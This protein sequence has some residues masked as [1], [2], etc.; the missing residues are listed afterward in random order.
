MRLS[1][2][3]CPLSGSW[4]SPGSRTELCTCSG[5]ELILCDV[6]TRPGP[7]GIATFRWPE[8]LFE[9]W[10][11]GP[12]ESEPGTSTSPHGSFV[13]FAVGA[14][15]LRAWDIADPKTSVGRDVALFREL[16]VTNGAETVEL[17]EMRGRLRGRL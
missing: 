15:T 5:L 14:G 1:S 7:A 2:S 12:P 10:V 13:F 4:L 17:E 3:N 9:D 16:V 6:V 11:S 8:E